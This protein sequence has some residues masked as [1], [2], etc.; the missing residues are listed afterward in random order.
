[1]ISVPGFSQTNIID[2]QVRK[3]QEPSPWIYGLAYRANT[4]MADDIQPRASTHFLSGYG[5]YKI[6]DKT[7]IFGGLSGA[8]DAFGNQ[9][10]FDDN[11]QELILNDIGVSI[12]HNI[13]IRPGQFL[14]LSL[15]NEFPTSADAK[16]EGYMSIT[17]LGVSYI[18]LFFKNKLILQ[19][20]PGLHYIWNTYESSPATNQSNKVGGLFV[21]ASTL[22]YYY[23]RFFL[24]AGAG[25]QFSQY[26]DGTADQ[27][28]RT[29]LSTGYRDGKWNVALSYSNGT[30][31]D[32]Q[33]ARFWYLDAYRQILS[34]S[35]GHNF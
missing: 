22:Y 24:G 28:Y 21:G 27:L 8:V 31:L 12:N 4:D 23:D 6:D 25:T 29:S 32:D 19:A 16:R 11:A 1:M 13:P 15:D 14:S 10:E 35:I 5:G 20:G 2:Q 9:V 17:S 26:V 3:Q 34:L 7:F 30:Y 33:E 18:S